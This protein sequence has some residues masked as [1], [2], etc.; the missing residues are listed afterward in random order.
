MAGQPCAA[1]FGPDDGGDCP[2]PEEYRGR[3]GV[4]NVYNQRIDD[5]VSPSLSSATSA[6]GPGGSSASTR[7]APSAESPAPRRVDYTFEHTTMWAAATASSDAL[8]TQ[9]VDDE[10]RNVEE[11]LLDEIRL[12]GEAYA[13]LRHAALLRMLHHQVKGFGAG[14]L[15]QFDVLV[16]LAPGQRAQPGG[17]LAADTAGA[18]RDAAHHP[19]V[20]HHAIARHVGCG[21][22]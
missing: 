22:G 13:E 21:R 20:A 12:D 15:A 19:Q 6:E 17:Q 7:A 3:H 16:D 14:L 5:P 4:F 18:D 10:A 2:V 8:A 1:G 11:W 9:V